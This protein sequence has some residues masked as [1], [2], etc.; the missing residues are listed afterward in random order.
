MKIFAFAVV[1]SAILGACSTTPTTLPDV[2]TITFVTEANSVPKPQTL[3]HPVITN[4]ERR[5]PTGPKP[6]RKLN[7]DQSP[8]NGING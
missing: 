4:F 8:A 7:D 1:I 6:W 2:S 5:E 3:H